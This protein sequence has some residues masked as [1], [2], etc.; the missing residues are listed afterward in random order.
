MKTFKAAPSNRG[1]FFMPNKN[2]VLV[3]ICAGFSIKQKN[4]IHN[5]LINKSFY[6]NLRKY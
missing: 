3:F 6:I 1:R 5:N 4:T 2:H